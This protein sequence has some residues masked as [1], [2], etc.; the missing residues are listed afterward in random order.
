MSGTDSPRS[1][2]QS[3][4]PA[5]G[6]PGLTG[7]YDLAIRLLTRERN[8]RSAL[9]DQ[10]A[11]SDGDAIIDVG[12]GTGSFAIMMKQVAPGARIVGLDPDSDVLRRAEAKARRAGVEIEWRQGFA[13]EVAGLGR[14]FDKA[15]SSLMFHQIPAAGKG[16]AVTA[17]FAAVRPGGEVHIADYARQPDWLMRTLFRA[18]VQMIDGRDD[19]QPSADGALE[20]ALARLTGMPVRPAQSVRTVT[21]AISLFREIRPETGVGH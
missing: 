8:W 1:T 4:T 21:G 3:F 12:C 15:V 11:P 16:P 10:V 17:M 2:D 19:T 6:W 20:A 14:R 7:A 13:N 18:S 5:L 9:L